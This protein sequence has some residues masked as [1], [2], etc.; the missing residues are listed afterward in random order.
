MKLMPLFIVVS[1]ACRSALPA[2]EPV[3]A[4]VVLENIAV[5]FSESGW[6]NRTWEKKSFVLR[7]NGEVEG[8]WAESGSFVLTS[9]Y[10]ATPSGTYSYQPLEE[11]G[12][13]ELVLFLD[14]VEV[15]VV[16]Q[17]RFH[18]ATVASVLKDDFFAFPESMR[19]TAMGGDQPML[20]V[21]NRVEVSAGGSAHTGFVLGKTGQYLVRVVGPTLREFGVEDAAGATGIKL[22][23]VG[24]PEH[25]I[26]FEAGLSAP[27]EVLRR[28]AQWV[29]AFP[30]VEDEQDVAVMVRLYPG[31]YVAEALNPTDQSGQVMIELY[32]LPF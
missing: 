23:R 21:S 6:N 13:A 32:A 9:G 26:I 19:I 25:D 30:L 10:R 7:P 24:F 16:K 14:G 3:E 12:R 11:T 31:T 4:P 17:L 20:N 1:L 2:A 5:T 8:L 22:H 18:S 27:S 29:G 28:A 15:P